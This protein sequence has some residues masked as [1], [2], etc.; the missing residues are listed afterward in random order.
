[1][2]KLSA[3]TKG[4]IRQAARHPVQWMRGD[5]LPEE[6]IRPWEMAAHI[7]PNLFSG[8]RN[9]FSWNTMYLFQ[10]VFGVNK[11]QQA[12]AS[13]ASAVWDGLND[14]V[15]G[16]YMDSKNYPMTIHRWIARVSVLVTNLIV[17]LPMFSFGLTPWQHIAVFIAMNVV[18][19]FF[20]TA[21][22]VS[23][24]KIWAHATPYSSERAKLSWASGIGGTIH[25]M[26]VPLYLVF[27]GL[28][29][30]IGLSEYSIYILGAA[31][32]T[33][34]TAFLS[35][36]PTYVLQRVP[37]NPTPPK[38]MQ[39][40]KDFFVELKDCF[41][42]VKHNKYFML[43]LAAKAI[44]VLTPGIGD[45]DFY[46]FCGVDEVLRTGKIKGEFLLWVR[47]NVVSAPGVFLQPFSLPIIK[48]VGGPRNMQ[49][50]YQGAFALCAGLR[51]AVGM[52][53]QFG[54]LFSW[55]MELIIRTLGKI[56]GIAGSI[57]S[58]EMLDYVEWKTGR[59]SEGVNMAVNGLLDK[60]VLNNVD[61]IIGNLVIDALGFDPKAEKQPALFMKWAPVLYLL[62]PAIDNFI[63][64]L[65]R[66]F[67]K[68]PASLRDQ[69]EADLIERRAL[70]EAKRGEL[71]REA[72]P[73]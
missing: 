41:V 4:Q 13:V 1:L 37:D 71:E 60:F 72:D 34:P 62:V 27:I 2:A 31:I 69:V 56:Q 9:G 29:E 42:I 70:A 36:G 17:I 21:S 45:N 23:H 39:S 3:E 53:S 66:L 25:E 15:I 19:D 5:G 7:V 28:R 67:Y 47:D 50:I 18:R 8:L 32:F 10:N 43:N 30:V 54:V 6:R 55:A 58:F 46:R 14:P 65:A 33:L 11:R 12:V 35:L 38:E 48:K 51:F 24:A 22:S 26:L 73:A 64:F 59:R 68:Y 44:T 61:T 52:R 49:V 63:Y 20:G 57:I 40:L 16:A